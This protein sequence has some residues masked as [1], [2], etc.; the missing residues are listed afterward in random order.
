M[1]QMAFIVAAGMAGLVLS[2]QSGFAQSET[3]N[4][5]NGRDYQPT[6]AEVQPR[7]RAAGIQAPAPQQQR[8]DKDLERIDRE[9]LR[10]HGMS[11]SSVPA[12][13]PTR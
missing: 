1:R 3:G 2:A 9:L 6:P 8:N 12:I 7:E 10:D 4:R 11:T 13:A 5:A